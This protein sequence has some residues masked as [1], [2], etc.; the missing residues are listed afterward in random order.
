MFYLLVTQ[1]LL[2]TNGYFFCLRSENILYFLYIYSLILIMTINLYNVCLYIVRTNLKLNEL[3]EVL[4]NN[5]ICN[6]S[7]TYLTLSPIR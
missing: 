7:I 5:L 3:L 4:K 1:L 6:S 2:I